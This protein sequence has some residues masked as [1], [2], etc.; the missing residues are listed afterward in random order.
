MHVH[1]YLRAGGQF[2]VYELDA[3]GHIRA[4]HAS[5]LTCTRMGRVLDLAWLNLPWW[6]PRCWGGMRALSMS[7]HVASCHAMS[8]PPAGVWAA[9]LPRPYGAG[10]QALWRSRTCPC[11][12]GSRA[13]EG[14]CAAGTL[15]VAGHEGWPNPKLLVDDD[16]SYIR[17]R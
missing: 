14:A 4:G 1:E 10:A 11:P 15:C 13:A 16:P 6:V 12:S 7:C 2:G 9:L 5:P 8:C 17:A 3:T